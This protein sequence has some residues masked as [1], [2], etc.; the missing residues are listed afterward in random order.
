[1]PEDPNEAIAILSDEGSA[2]APEATPVERLIAQEIET[3]PEAPSFIASPQR[4][5]RGTLLVLAGVILPSVAIFIELTTRIC[6]EEFFDPLPTTWHKILVIATPLANLLLIYELRRDRAEYHW[7]LGLAN[8]LAVVVSTFYTILYLPIMPIALVALV[9]AGLGILPMSPMFSL[10]ASAILLRRLRAL[11]REGRGVYGPGEARLRG[12]GWGLAMTALILV[13]AEVPVILT[14]VWVSKAAS[15]SQGEKARAIDLLRRYGHD[16]TLLA[17]C[18]R[19]GDFASLFG[20]FLN[21]R[22]PVSVE[23]AREIFYRVTG[24]LYSSARGDGFNAFAIDD[25]THELDETGELRG[26]SQPNLSLAGSRIDGSFDPDAAL[27]YLEW[28]MVFKNTS[29]FQQE[30][31]AR[32]ALPHAGLVW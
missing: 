8:G 25:L 1:M 4:Q 23:L 10:I 16:R 20:V 22:Y 31:S 14:R 18:D 21:S 2:G 19:R 24:K 28:T 12:F 9:F 6:A 11:R 7:K 3:K 13:A 30:A 27:G 5:K 15:D 26:L 32:L 29:T 17:A